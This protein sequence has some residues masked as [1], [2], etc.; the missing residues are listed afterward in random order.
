ML[1]HHSV[2]ELCEITTSLAHQAAGQDPGL[3][4][5][6]ACCIRRYR[7]VATPLKGDGTVFAKLDLD[8]P[9]GD[10]R[11][12]T[13]PTPPT[14]RRLPPKCSG[15]TDEAVRVVDPSSS[16]LA[17][18]ALGHAQWAHDVPTTTV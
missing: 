17:M 3:Y 1:R 16:S 18:Y 14:R 7:I 12:T 2:K 6:I 9:N 10:F 4:K 11:V 5:L 15:L 13:K 8:D